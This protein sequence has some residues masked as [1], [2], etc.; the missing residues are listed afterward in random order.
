MKCRAVSALIG[1]LAMALIVA[2][3]GAAAGVRIANGSVGWK[4]LSPQVRQRIASNAGG[5][6]PQGPAGPM[7]PTGA[8]GPL[9]DWAEGSVL[10]YSSAG[11]NQPL[12]LNRENGAAQESIGPLTL[13][14]SCVAEGEDTIRGRLRRQG[15]SE[16]RH[17]RR[18]T[19]GPGRSPNRPRTRGQRRRLGRKLRRRR[20]GRDARRIVRH[21]GRREPPSHPPRRL[22]LFRDVD[23][24]L[25]TEGAGS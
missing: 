1:A 18:Q 13:F 11:S 3:A 19:P 20:Q 10:T 25:M 6:G 16:R 21:A 12:V 15:E 7:G 17:L 9:G 2:G 8:P 22:P 14:A 5:Q 24:R 23:R 4:K